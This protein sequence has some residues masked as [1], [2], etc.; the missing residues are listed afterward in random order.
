M[1]DRSIDP[2]DDWDL[3]AGIRDGKHAALE[4]LYRK[5]IVDVYRFARAWLGDD[6]SAEDVCQEVF[7]AVWSDRSRL[8]FSGESFLPWLVAAARYRCLNELRR[9]VRHPT[10]V[11]NEAAAMSTGHSGHLGTLE[12]ADEVERMLGTLSP[13]DRSILQAVVVDELSYAEASQKVGLSEA[14][15]RNRLSRAKR[16]L[17]VGAAERSAA[18]RNGGTR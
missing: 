16:A 17:R 15:V 6:R 11:L 3:V 10:E 9:R 13:V 4:F 18:E 2:P 12:V 8:R 1:S 14:A 7:T 5:Y